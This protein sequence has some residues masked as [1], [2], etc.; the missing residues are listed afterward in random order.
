MGLF[1]NID[2]LT[3]VFAD[4][5]IDS[6]FFG[7]TGS[8]ISGIDEILGNFRPMLDQV[9]SSVIMGGVT[10]PRVGSMDDDD[11]LI[12]PLLQK[13]FGVTLYS[14]SE[15]A[16][17]ALAGLVKYWQLLEESKLAQKPI[18]LKADTTAC[19]KIIEKLL[20]TKGHI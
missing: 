12:Q 18:K 5:N 8:G 9:D 1:T 13:M 17:R 15:R 14:T 7:F 20:V 10:V 11:K 6:W 2:V 16:I 19:R 3:Q 4:P